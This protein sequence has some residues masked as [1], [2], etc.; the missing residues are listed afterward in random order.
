MRSTGRE[1]RETPRIGARARARA[2]RPSIHALSDG[3]RL[4]RMAETEDERRPRRSR[5]RES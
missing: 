4:L 1:R 2:L 3:E 5:T